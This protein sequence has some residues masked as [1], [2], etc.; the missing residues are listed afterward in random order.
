MTSNPLPVSLYENLLLKL[1]AVLE[2]THQE[3]GIAT[4]AAKQTILQAVSVN[5]PVERARLLMWF[6]DEWLQKC[7]RSS[8]RFSRKSSRRWIAHSGARAAYPNARDFE[9]PEEVRFFEF[10]CDYFFW[11]RKPEHNWNISHTSHCTHRRYSLHKIRWK[12]TPW[13]LLLRTVDYSSL[14][15]RRLIGRLHW[16]IFVF[17]Y[18]DF[19]SLHFTHS[20]LPTLVVISVPLSALVP[21]FALGCVQYGYPPCFSGSG[22]NLLSCLPRS[23]WVTRRRLVVSSRRCRFQLWRHHYCEVD[24]IF[25]FGLS[26]FQIMHGFCSH[27]KDVVWWSNGSRKGERGKGRW[28]WE[29]WYD[30]LATSWAGGGW[31]HGHHV[32]LLYP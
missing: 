10:V 27:A 8:K 2:L 23:F 29:L 14:N 15:H 4:P 31:V 28:E 5:L 21:K 24:V 26:W 18:F 19:F 1:V 22:H 20:S 13:L 17:P 9:K 30:C 7:T 25:C 11:K 6:L 16:N 12:L 3:E 32:C